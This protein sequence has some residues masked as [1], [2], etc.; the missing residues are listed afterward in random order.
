MEKLHQIFT[1]LGQAY[2]DFTLDLHCN[3]FGPTALFQVWKL[4]TICAFELG[5]FCLV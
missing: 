5:Y 4:L 2:G 3:R 1:T